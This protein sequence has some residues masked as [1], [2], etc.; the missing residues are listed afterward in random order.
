MKRAALVGLLLLCNAA[1]ANSDTLQVTGGWF[2]LMPPGVGMTA[3]YATLAN[4][5][6]TTLE[7]VTV[8]CSPWARCSLHET[9]AD[10]GGSRMR[11]ALPLRL[12]PGEEKKLAPG[13]LHVMA[14][15]LK[16]SLTAGQ[17][18]RVIFVDRDGRRHAAV[19]RVEK[20]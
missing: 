10:E 2:R 19:F 3:G 9:V 4:R 15:D 16:D 11:P 17:S 5:S 12:L 7:L 13:G 1:S 6:G 18:L 14:M 8:D 20:P